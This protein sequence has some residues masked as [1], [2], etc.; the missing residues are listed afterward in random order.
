MPKIF[1]PQILDKY[2][3]LVFDAH[4]TDVVS[5][6]SKYN[7]RCNICG[8]SAKRSRIKRAYI[9]KNK[10]PWVFYCHN[11]NASMTVE[12]WLKTYFNYYYRTYYKEVFK[13]DVGLSLRSTNLEL[14]KQSIEQPYNEFEDVK[15]FVGLYKNPPSESVYALQLKAREYC[16]NR[17]I[18]LDVRNKWYVA[19]DGIFK[20][21]LIIPCYD[22]EGRIYSWQA[23]SLN[24]AIPKYITR[25]G[26]TNSIYNYYNV[27]KEK[28]VV[29]VEGYIDSLFIENC[30]AVCGLKI[31]DTRLGV[32]KK[33]FFLLDNDDAGRKTSGYLLMYGEYVFL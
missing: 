16:I 10:K 3:G 23:R 27:D 28:P 24:G 1:N 31:R 15:H 11:C 2:L 9:L 12:W 5:D 8:D 14:K 20:D 21:R 30:I 26:A 6:G 13:L 7:F 19:T 18:S 4:F 29:V 33:R 32:F 22:N 17:L 25:K